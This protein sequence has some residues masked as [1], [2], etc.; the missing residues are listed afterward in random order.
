LRNE[1]AGAERPDFSS[2]EEGRSV[3]QIDISDTYMWD[4]EV[5]VLAQP[6]RTALRADFGGR[7]ITIKDAAAPGLLLVAI[8]H[9]NVTIDSPIMTRVHRFQATAQ[10]VPTL[11]MT[12]RWLSIQ[13][14]PTIRATVAW[15]MI[16]TRILYK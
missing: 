13:E 16:K 12:G 14:Y 1:L 5:R 10:P 9:R 7:R 15:K 11:E 4:S 2:F 8:I 3:I 6:S